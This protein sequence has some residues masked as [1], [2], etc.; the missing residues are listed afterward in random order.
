MSVAT[1]T[2]QA[3]LIDRPDD[4][5][6][7]RGKARA[8]AAARVPPERT[9]WSLATEGARDLFG[10]RNAEAAK[11]PPPQRAVRASKA[12]LQLAGSVVL[13]R[14]RNRF[15][16]LYRLLWRLQDDAL[17]MQS[18]SD[19]DVHRLTA[20]AG[21]VRRDIHKMRAFL[22]F[23]ATAE[24]D[25]GERFV[26]WFE[27]DHHIVR[28]NADF[29]LNRFA[30][31]RWSILTPELC[32]HWDGETLAEAPG[33]DRRD[34]PAE[35]V[36]E[37]LWQS[38]YASIFNPARLKVAAMVKEMPRR[39]WKN[40]PEAR[41]IPGLI[42]GAQAREAAMVERGGSRFDRAPPTSL[43]AIAGRIEA[44]R[45]CP[46]G[47]NGTRAV[48]GEGP[49]RAR[50]LIVGEQPGD[51]EERDGRPFVGPAGQLLDRHLERAGLDRSLIRLTNAVRHFKFEQ[52]GKRR[53]HQNPTAG[54]IDRC[55]WW[56]DAERRLV[57]PEVIL[58]LGASAGRA[59]LG[60]TP[61]IGKER[62]E[63]R[64]L[65]DGSRLVLTMHPS[66]LLRLRDDAAI[67]AERR[68]QSDLG[69]VAA[70]LQ[71]RPAPAALAPERA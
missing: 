52:R 70:L 18:T 46:I 23:R 3:V 57:R 4:F 39:Y 68:F 10:A 65:P 9:S 71:I 1:A 13:H 17:L 64:S 59:I 21:H 62:G 51:C 15:A 8:L 6:E 16:M 35:D 69:R 2:M 28:A 41:L 45:Q 7:W 55:R 20:M 27:P 37:H 12:F 43:E 40:L 50:L 44:C 42:A 66:Y 53:I 22:R 54:E 56:L 14:D 29:F 24:P 61:S 49:A 31:Q 58:A 38:Y 5:E 19:P 63:V 33:A 67:D 30:S 26:A 48:A 60:R 11:S 34:A 47:C 32:L 36:A 25:G